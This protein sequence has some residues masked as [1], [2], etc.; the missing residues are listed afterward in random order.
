MEHAIGGLERCPACPCCRDIPRVRR[1]Q[2]ANFFSGQLSSP[3]PPTPVTRRS[4]RMSPPRVFTARLNHPDP[5]LSNLRS[6]TSGNVSRPHGRSR[7][8]P[9]QRSWLWL[10]SCM[11]RARRRLYSLVCPSSKRLSLRSLSRIQPAGQGIGSHYHHC[12]P[13]IF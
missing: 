4:G 8:R 2:R 9:R 11:C 12:H 5:Y 1:Q 3:C 7:L 10:P 13:G 6:L